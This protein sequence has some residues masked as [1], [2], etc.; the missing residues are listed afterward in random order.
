MFFVHKVFLWVLS[1][2]CQKQ[3]FLQFSSLNVAAV[4]VCYTACPHQP[5]TTR[6][7]QNRLVTSASSALQPDVSDS[8]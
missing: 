5:T 6:T 4:I 3:D 1:Q 8:V 7:K 2:R